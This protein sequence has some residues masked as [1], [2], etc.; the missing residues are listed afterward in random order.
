MYGNRLTPKEALN[1]I[2]QNTQQLR[3]QQKMSREELAERSGV[4][5]SSIRKFET[6]G[7]IS[8][9]SLLKL[10]QVFDRLDDFTH[11]LL[12]NENEQKQTLFDI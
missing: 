1:S 11:L 3:K 2:A 6:T 10:A 4:S 8:L 5:Y 12:P 7:K 9:E